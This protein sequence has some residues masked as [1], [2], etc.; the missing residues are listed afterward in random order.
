MIRLGKMGWARA[1]GLAVAVSLVTSCGPIADHLV[2]GGMAAA[3][4]DQIMLVRQDP[5]SFGY[6]RLEMEMRAYPDLAAL[7]A[8]RELPDFLAETGNSERRYFILYYLKDRQ[9]YACRTREGTKRGGVEFAGPYPIT[10]G[11]FRLLD[12]FRRDLSRQ[13]QDF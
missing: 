4:K 2:E 13:P 7:V 11:E 8:K 1:L 12:G 3:A 5:P 9:A 10:D 6:Q